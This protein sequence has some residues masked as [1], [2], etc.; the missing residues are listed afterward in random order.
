MSDHQAIYDAV[1]SRISNGDVGSAVGSAIHDM[2]L[3]HYVQQAMQEFA[4]AGSEYQRPCVLYRPKVFMDGKQWCA[5][6]GE[7]LMQGVAAFGETPAK[8]CEAFDKIW[9]EGVKP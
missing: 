2:N 9:R 1:R 3:S 5:L 7:D 4:Y 8:A 6:Y